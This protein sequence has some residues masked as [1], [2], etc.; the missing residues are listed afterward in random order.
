[1]CV[2]KSLTPATTA[3]QAFAEQEPLPAYQAVIGQNATCTLAHG[4]LV[5]APN[6]N[7]Q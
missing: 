1:M 6:T 5:M 2:L 7:T 3:T 4:I